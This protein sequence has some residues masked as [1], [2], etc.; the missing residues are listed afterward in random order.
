VS[1]DRAI[2]AVRDTEATL[3]A[4]LGA[5]GERHRDDHDVFHMSRT[6]ATLHRENLEA[7][8]GDGAL[9]DPAL[10]GDL[11]ADLR[12]LHLLYAAASVDWVL[13]GQGAQAVRDGATLATVGECHPRTVKGMK[14][15]L[16]R[17]KSA[18]PQVLAR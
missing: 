17:L 9:S 5:I 12:T 16:T 14:W 11:L 1:I 13:L 15:T 8:G 10:D 2:A 3:V 7:L 6:L 4:A 18:A